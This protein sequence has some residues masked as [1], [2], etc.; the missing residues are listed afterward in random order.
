MWIAGHES[1]FLARVCVVLS[2]DSCFVLDGFD[3]RW[4]VE[5]ASV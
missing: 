5:V 4:K 3:G 2:P 1:R